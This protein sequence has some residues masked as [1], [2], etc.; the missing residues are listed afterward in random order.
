V[1]GNK[2]KE[3]EE[4]TMEIIRGKGEKREETNRQ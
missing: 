4:E 1:T 2:E 3:V